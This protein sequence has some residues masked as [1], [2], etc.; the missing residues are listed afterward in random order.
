GGAREIGPIGSPARV[1]TVAEAALGAEQLVAALRRGG[2]YRLRFGGG[3]LGSGSEGG[4]QRHGSRRQPRERAS[5]DGQFLPP[6]PW[7]AEPHSIF[8][9]PPWLQP[10]CSAA[11]SPDWSPARS[12]RLS[13]RGWDC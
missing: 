2:V 1:R 6:R 10:A 3:G 9:T 7:D 12:P 13:D 4:G 11:G 5:Q 8:R